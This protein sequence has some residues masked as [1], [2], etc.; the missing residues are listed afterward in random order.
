MATQ[1][2]PGVSRR[3]FVR[4]AIALAGALP[5]APAPAGA[6]AIAVAPTAASGYRGLNAS[7]AVCVEAIVNTLCPADALTSNGVESG[8]AAFI[9]AHL[10][11][12][13]D[14]GTLAHRELFTTGIA[15]IDAAS[16]ARFGVGLDRLPFDQAR[17]FLREVAA[18]R[19]DAAF[20]LESWWADVLEPVLTQACF[21]GR[22]Y[23]AVGSRMFVKLFG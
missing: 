1:T 21:S 2:Q 4:G 7:E 12:D 15:S 20:P 18:G 9:D 8:L 3:G 17:Q 22:V 5:F 14:A 6:A 10:A 11:G 23:D 16:H 19:V 13:I